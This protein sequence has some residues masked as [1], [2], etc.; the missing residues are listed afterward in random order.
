M[1]ST[2]VSYPDSICTGYIQTSCPTFTG[3]RRGV[4]PDVT[5]FLSPHTQLVIRMEGCDN[6]AVEFQRVESLDQR[7]LSLAEGLDTRHCLC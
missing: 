5:C 7:M 2:S 1:R 6:Q 4:H 3:L